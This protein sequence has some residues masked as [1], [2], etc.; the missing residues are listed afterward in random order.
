MKLTKYIYDKSFNDTERKVLHYFESMSPE[1]L[2]SLH[3][4][5]VADANFTSISSIFCLAKKL[6]FDGFKEMVY[7]LSLDANKAEQVDIDSV[8]LLKATQQL[9]D[10]FK[11]NEK[12]FEVY[13]QFFHEKEQSIVIIGNGYSKIM[14]D[15]LGMRFM[16]LGYRVMVLSSADSLQSLRHNIDHATQLICVSKSGE[17]SSLWPFLDIAQQHQVPIVSFSQNKRAK[18]AKVS[19]FQFTIN[20]NQLNN[21]DNESLS[22]FFPNLMLYLEFLVDQLQRK[23]SVNDRLQ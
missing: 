5:Q 1:K 21:W 19:T 23:E 10:L 17:T 2:K 14:A 11:I 20:D 16:N 13:R 18:L 6:G 3:I 12:T 22:L 4:Q 8:N 9:L 15:F 7:H